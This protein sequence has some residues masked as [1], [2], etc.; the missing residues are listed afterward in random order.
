MALVISVIRFIYMP[1]ALLR[2]GRAGSQ[3]GPVG[4]ILKR[5]SLKKCFCSP[6]HYFEAEGGVLHYVII[7]FLAAKITGCPGFVRSV[8]RVMN[9]P[10]EPVHVEVKEFAVESGPAHGNLQIR[11]ELVAHALGA[12]ALIF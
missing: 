8:V 12:L 1:A 7:L 3:I 11:R 6:G 10:I 2:S 4:S 9:S 5:P